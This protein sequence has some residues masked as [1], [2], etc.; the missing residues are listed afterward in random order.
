MLEL[1][2][3]EGSHVAKWSLAWRANGGIRL[4]QMARPGFAESITPSVS[5]SRIY[6]DLLGLCCRRSQ[7]T[8]YHNEVWI[9]HF[10]MRTPPALNESSVICCC[11]AATERRLNPSIVNDNTAAPYPGTKVK[12]ATAA[13]KEIAAKVDPIMKF[14]STAPFC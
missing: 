7:L 3:A 6:N 9:S 5:L 8:G 11:P 10:P 1:G 14:H 13:G 12:K 4:S 2:G